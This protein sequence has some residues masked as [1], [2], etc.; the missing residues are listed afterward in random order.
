MKILVLT[1]RYTASRD[2]VEEKFGRQIKLFE[3]IAKN[4]QVDFYCLDYKKFEKKNAEVNGIKIFIRPFSMKKIISFLIGFRRK[5]KDGRYD[6]IVAASDPLWGIM[7]Y[8]FSR[9]YRIP[10]AYDIQDNYE[11][12]KSYR[13]PFVPFFDRTVSKRAELVIGASSYLSKRAEKSRKNPTITIVNGADLELFKPMDK[14]ECRK[15]LNLP[16]DA[17]II[18][19]I[20]TFQKL[21]GTDILVEEFLKLKKEIPNLR[22]LMAGKFSPVFNE[23]KD[24][25][26]PQEGIIYLGSVPQKDV[27]CAINASDAMIIPYP[28]NIFT[29]AIEASYKVIE[30]MACNKPI[31]GT[32]AGDIHKTLGHKELIAKAGDR[33]D[34]REKIK[35]ALN[36]ESV[37]YGKH[38]KEF[39]W[40]ALSKKLEDGIKKITSLP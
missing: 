20:G 4:N 37:D 29:E 17:K 6:V 21:Y 12:Y 11:T 36:V 40:G 5:I 10:L 16:Q 13:I 19:Y 9:V 31:V 26:L 18:S 32:D 23:E 35:K 33:E 39:G 15:K 24:I 14:I 3:Q 1:S 7:G 28:Q 27:V 38:L 30:F 22:L 25:N 8:L 34:L 2:I